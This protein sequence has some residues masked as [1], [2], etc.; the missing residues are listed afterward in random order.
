MSESQTPVQDHRCQSGPSAR[1]SF[2]PSEGRF[3]KKYGADQQRL[4][5]SELHCDKFPT[6]VAFAC[7][8]IR[9][10]TEV[11]T[12]SQFLTEDMQWMKEVELVDSVD[13]KKTSCSVRGIHMPNFEVLDAKIASALNRIIQ[14]TQFKRR[15]S[16]EEHKAQKEDRFLRG[17]QI[18]Y[19][20]YECFRVTGANDS[21]E[22]YADLFSFVLRNDDTQEFDS[23]WDGNLLSMTQ[24]PSDDIMERLYKLRTR[25]SEKLK[26]VLEL[27]NMELHQKK[28]GLDYH[29]LKTMV[30]RSVEQDLRN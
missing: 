5:I 12:R 3:L 15:I 2:V 18:A 26:T 19:L 17:R 14:N 10:K 27:Y 30:K 4:Q 29:R 1:N 8:K 7:W 22:N 21:V 11:C 13:E 23:K 9:F 16:L 28:I 24:I 20:M 6:P 25:E